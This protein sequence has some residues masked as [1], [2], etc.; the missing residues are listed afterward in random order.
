MEV[1]EFLRASVDNL[2]ERVL[3][4]HGLKSYGILFHHLL[5]RLVKMVALKMQVRIKELIANS[6]SEICLARL[7]KVDTLV[8]SILVEILELHFELNHS[9]QEKTHCVTK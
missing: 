7:R 3:R 6:L 2:V 9:I 1:V 4:A 8:P 5:E